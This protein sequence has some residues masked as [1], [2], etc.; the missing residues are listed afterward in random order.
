MLPDAS[1]PVK[2]VIANELRI[3]GLP[4]NT[5]QWIM[6]ARLGWRRFNLTQCPYSHYCLY[7]PLLSNLVFE[8]AE[9][10]DVGCHLRVHEHSWDIDPLNDTFNLSYRSKNAQTEFFQL[11]CF[12]S[13]LFWVYC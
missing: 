13:G 7:C 6:N 11:N 9:L 2:A 1:A 10:R 5:L 8:V 12:L 3:Q 4:Q